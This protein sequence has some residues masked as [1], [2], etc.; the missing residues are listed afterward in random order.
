MTHHSLPRYQRR[1]INN[2]DMIE[3]VDRV[4]L[5]L[6]DCLSIAKLAL[7]TLVQH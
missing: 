2:D 5:K 3:S 1:Q 6:A 4:D 7:D